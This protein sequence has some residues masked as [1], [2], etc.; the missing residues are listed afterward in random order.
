MFSLTHIPAGNVSGTWSFENS[1]YLIDG[2]IEIPNG[3]WH[4]IRFEDTPTEN[5][6]SKIVF[7][8]LE[9]GKAIGKI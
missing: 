4:G 3:G 1:P 8:K 5:D 6:S 9:F 7:C 2:E